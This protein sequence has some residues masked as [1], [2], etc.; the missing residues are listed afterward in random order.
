[1]HFVLKSVKLK[2][3]LLTHCTSTYLYQTT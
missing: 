3:S 2:G 1:M